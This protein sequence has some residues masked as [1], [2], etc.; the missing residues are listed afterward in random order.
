MI[1][2]IRGADPRLD[3]TLSPVNQTNAQ[4]SR[5]LNG[6]LGV[7][8]LLSRPEHRIREQRLFLESGMPLYQWVQGQQLGRSWTLNA[9]WGMTF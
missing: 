9:G 8:Y 3:P 1:G 5:Y 7:N 4:A 2:D 6:L